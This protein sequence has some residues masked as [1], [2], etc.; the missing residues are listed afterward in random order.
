MPSEEPSNEFTSSHI[1]VKRV[2]NNQ[3][4][5]LSL[6]TLTPFCHTSVML[7][8]SDGAGKDMALLHSSFRQ[9]TQ[10]LCPK[11]KGDQPSRNVVVSPS[12]D[13]SRV[14]RAVGRCWGRPPA[15]APRPGKGG[16]GGQDTTTPMGP[17]LQSLM[18]RPQE[19]PGPSWVFLKSQPQ[20]LAVLILKLKSSWNLYQR[21]NELFS[22]S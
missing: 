9:W 1:F 11:R 2:N 22:L 21:G 10:P 14:Q 20:G 7:L 3:W 4:R 18:L 12:Q 8:T 17:Q 19:M 13:P 5:L 16:F 6:P 15:T